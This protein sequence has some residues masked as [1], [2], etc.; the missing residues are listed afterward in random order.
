MNQSWRKI[1]RNFMSFQRSDRNAIII[2]GFLIMIVVVANFIVL[3][4]SPKSS[5]DFSEVKAMI[6]SWELAR[7]EKIESKK[8]VFFEF[9]PNTVSEKTLDSLS[10]P[11]FIKQNIS[12][13]RKAGGKFNT[14]SDVRKI[15]GMNDSIFSL[16]EE[17]IRIS[18]SKIESTYSKPTTKSK[19]LSPF[20][21]NTIDVDSLRDY[22]FTEF[23]TG[24]IVK[25]RNNGGVFYQSFDLLKIYGID[26]A[27]FVKISPYVKIEQKELEPD[28]IGIEVVKI[29]LN[30]ADSADLVQLKGI[31]PA[32]ANRIIKYREILGGYYNKEQIKEVY[33]FP[34]ELYQQVEGYIFVDTTAIKKLRINFSE[35]SELLRH[36]YFSK[37]EVKLMLDKRDRDGAYKNIDDLQVLEGFD[38]EKVKKIRPYIS[39]R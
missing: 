29:E 20:D 16:L 35:F 24:N 3:Q 37:N 17:Y 32:Y 27:F 6:N 2:I 9:D 25:Y 39:C 34:E 7:A 31:G 26:S 4:M 8:A 21:P 5:S 19:P 18:R 36:P 23:Q 13:Y 12:S 10:I 14:S 15:Y 28:P 33:N 1:V 30:S 22:G 38:S 11:A